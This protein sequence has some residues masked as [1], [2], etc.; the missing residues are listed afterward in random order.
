MKKRTLSE[1]IEVLRTRFETKEPPTFTQQK[2]SVVLIAWLVKITEYKVHKVFLQFFWS[3]NDPKPNI[4]N[5]FKNEFAKK[6][7]TK[8][9][10][11]GML[12]LQLTE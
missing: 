12:L 1:T 7:Q 11:N 4:N 6:E 9:S 5:S 10:C 2:V 3:L 8:I